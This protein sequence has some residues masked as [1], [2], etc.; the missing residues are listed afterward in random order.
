MQVIN[1]K[2]NGLTICQRFFIEKIVEMLYMGTIDSYRVRLNNPLTVMEEL[3]YCLQEFKNGRIKHFHTIKTKENKKYALIDECIDSLS[4]TPNYLNFHSISQ[5]YLNTTLKNIDEHNYLK[6]ISCLSVLRKENTNYLSHVINGLKQLITANNH[7]VEELEKIDITLNILLSQLINIGY[8]KGYLYKI[9]YSTFVNYLTDE[10]SFDAQFDIFEQKINHLPKEYVVIF[11]MDTTDKVYDAITGIVTESFQ[12]EDTI[13]GIAL[14]GH[15]QREF[16]NFNAQNANRKFLR[17]NVSA[18]DYLAALK[19]ARSI[20][21]EYLDVINLGLSDEYLNIHNRV[22]V[23]DNEN[24]ANGDFQNNINILDGKYKVTMDHYQD[25]TSKIPAILNNQ[26][27]P[28]E[29][30]DK[31]KSAVRYLRLGNQSTEVEHKFINY[32]IGLEY[33]FSNYESQN[34]I[35]RIKEHF[36]NAHARAYVKRNC[37]SLLKGINQLSARKKA[38]IPLFTNELSNFLNSNLYIQ[39]S[40]ELSA[41]Y[42]LLSYRTAKL[43][44]W[45]LNKDGTLSAT[46]YLTKHKKN[47]E[48]HFTRIYR[49]RNEIIHDAATNTN[50][51]HIASNL[52]Y[53]LTFILNEIIDY[54]HTNSVSIEDYFISNEI[55]LGNIEFQGN[56]LPDI[57]NINCSLD[58]I[59]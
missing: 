44:K 49:L 30:K 23:I 9:A 26:H 38:K 32:W 40:S 33:L 53:Y 51:E 18:T 31:I 8:S 17:C 59:N 5:K 36:I 10:K 58:F 3:R 48:I 47:L 43:S 2:K 6:V 50:N 41:D 13:Q 7:A 15:R 19:K 34:T 4:L 22:L 11:R 20:L 55:E 29:T 28:I 42:P 12:L 37:F 1:H 39:I 27:I 25:F 14:A 16:D 45:F 54:L 35:N 21:S 56:K 24:P 52:R 46:D 57:F